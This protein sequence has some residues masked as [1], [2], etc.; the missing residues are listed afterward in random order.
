MDGVRAAAGK[1]IG[2]SKG[3]LRFRIRV[4]DQISIGIAVGRPGATTGKGVFQTEVV[5]HLVGQGSALVVRRSDRAVATERSPIDH[6]TVKTFS[7][8]LPLRQIRHVAEIPP[9]RVRVNI[10]VPTGIP[11]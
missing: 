2:A 3:G 6:D 10:H 8:N 7:G 9:G 1:K 11:G 5:P 4:A